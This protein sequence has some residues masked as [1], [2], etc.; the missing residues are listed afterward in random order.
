[1]RSAPSNIWLTPYTININYIWQVI[2][3]IIVDNIIQLI[4]K[5]RITK[6]K[7][8]YVHQNERWLY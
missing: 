1:M 6:L 3:T 8:K 2:Q 7:D 5:S 4:V